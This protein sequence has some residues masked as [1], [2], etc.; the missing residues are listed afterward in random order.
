MYF[1]PLMLSYAALDG[2]R[3]KVVTSKLEH[4][5]KSCWF[6]GIFGIRREADRRAKKKGINLGMRLFRVEFCDKGKCISY[7]IIFKKNG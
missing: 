2:P 5:R 1:Y 6:R 7:K 4:D 3:R